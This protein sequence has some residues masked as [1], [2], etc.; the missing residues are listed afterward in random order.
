MSI[1]EIIFVFVIKLE[2]LFLILSC[3][4]NMSNIVTM[5]KRFGRKDNQNAPLELWE[6]LYWLEHNEIFRIMLS[7]SVCIKYSRLEYATGGTGA[8]MERCSRTMDFN[9]VVG[10]TGHILYFFN[11]LPSVVPTNQIQAFVLIR[12]H[13]DLVYH[14]CQLLIIFPHQQS[15]WL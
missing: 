2:Q 5:R 12:A 9:T 4:W 10:A 3:W 13:S 11:T 14:I 7:I 15:R 8:K 1:I 6:T